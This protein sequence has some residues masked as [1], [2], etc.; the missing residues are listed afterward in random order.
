M[1][2]KN[3]NIAQIFIEHPLLK[4]NIKLKKA[5]ISSLEYFTSKYSS[6]D[7]WA[8]KVLKLYISN[9][10]KQ[11]NYEYNSN[12]LE[13]IKIIQKT[14][15]RWFEFYNYFYCFIYD[16]LFINSFDDKK[17]GNLILEDLY[18]LTEKKDSDFFKVF[19]DETEMKNKYKNVENFRKYLKLNKDHQEKP[20]KKVLLVGTLSSGKSSLINALVGKKINKVQSSTCTSK[21]HH[22][23]EKPYEDNLI[24]EW[25][26]ELELNADKETLMLNNEDNKENKI[27]IGTYFNTFTNEKKYRLH[28]IDSPGI[29]S[30]TY[31][32]HK[33]I[34]NSVLNNEKI[35]LLIYVFNAEHIA[36]TDDEKYLKYLRENYKGKILFLVNKLDT[37]RIKDDSVSQTLENLEK[38]LIRLE[39]KN[40][41]IYPISAYSA[42][43]AKTK[44]FNNDLDDYETI[45][46]ELL[47]KKLSKK[48]YKFN[49]YF[50][51]E[52]INLSKL[53]KDHE[54]LSFPESTGIIQLE[55]ILYNL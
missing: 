19:Y 34:T 9:F 33:E 7:L 5:Y 41:E 2:I 15:F 40:L 28:L 31:K 44:I 54:E 36:T 42:F 22:I 4:E 21:A 6:K 26:H 53:E 10:F 17:K 43:L 24:Y 32:E 12:I 46:Y 37:F 38:Y 23:L 8:N 52:I 55:T 49:K 1:E 48:E 3:L 16:C 18:K 51:E 14:R 27:F 25:D 13:N 29:N 39:F 45:D 20:E 35:D 50:S 30:S 47:E 11:E